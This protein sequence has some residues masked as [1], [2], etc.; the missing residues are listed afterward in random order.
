MSNI[1]P[2]FITFMLS[3]SFSYPE[4]QLSLSKLA[5]PPH[6]GG[7]DFKII[8]EFLLIISIRLTSMLKRYRNI[9]S[10]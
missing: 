8:S 5:T 9:C 1:L 6:V 4:V 3:K 7:H 2:R 10:N